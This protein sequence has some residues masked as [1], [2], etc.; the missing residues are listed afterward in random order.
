MLF[1][2]VLLK[3]KASIKRGYYHNSTD[4]DNDFV[5][6]F[7]VD[8][9]SWEKNLEIFLAGF[10]ETLIGKDRI[11]ERQNSLQENHH[12]HHC[13]VLLSIYV[14][15]SS[16]IIIRNMTFLS[17]HHFSTVINSLLK[18]E[19]ADPIAWLSQNWE[20]TIV[21]LTVKKKLNFLDAFPISTFLVVTYEED[22]FYD[23]IW[24]VEIWHGWLQSLEDGCAVA[25]GGDYWICGK[26]KHRETLKESVNDLSMFSLIWRGGDDN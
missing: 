26:I 12:H 10:G 3:K 7:L 25:V 21:S 13:V 5:A 20:K 15:S 11:S 8:S 14:S 19:K 18:Q 6:I 9:K 16:S 2:I 17:N 1:Y 24:D 22:N 4:H 23:N